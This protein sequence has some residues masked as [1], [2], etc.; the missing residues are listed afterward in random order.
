MLWGWYSGEGATC[1]RE[2][3]QTL[4]S[5]ACQSF[6]DAGYH[7]H[8]I[9]I[10]TFWH[11]HKTPSLIRFWSK[12]SLA[13]HYFTLSKYQTFFLVFT[14]SFHLI[15]GADAMYMASETCILYGW[16]KMLIYSETCGWKINSSGSKYLQNHFSI[17]YINLMTND[18]QLSL[19][20]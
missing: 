4:S 3:C 20:S 1:E 8:R 10:L 13:D 7:H 19:K 2:R 18:K 14:T 17:L 5:R 16:W 12:K 6:L 9:L 15:D 11:I